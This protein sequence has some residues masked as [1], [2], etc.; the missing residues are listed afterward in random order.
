[1]NY[2][3]GHSHRFVGG[4]SLTINN[5]QTAKLLYISNVPQEPNTKLAYPAILSYQTLSKMAKFLSGACQS[6][7]AMHT[8]NQEEG[9]HDEGD[10]MV[11][12]QSIW[13]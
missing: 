5:N 1:M 3:K 13:K 11:V 4:I 6:T 9:I 7:T 2:K 8:A 10:M 12:R